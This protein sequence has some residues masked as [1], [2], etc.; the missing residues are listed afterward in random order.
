MTDLLPNYFGGRW[1]DG[2][3]DGATLRDPVTGTALVRVSSEGL[4]LANAFAYARD[5]GGRA[6]RALTLWPACGDAGRDRQDAAGEPGR[7]LRHRDRQLRHDARRLRGG[8]R[9]RASTRSASTRAGARRSATRALCRR[10]A[11]PAGQGR[12]SSS[13][14]HVLVPARGVALFINAFN[15]PAWGLW[16]KAAAALLSG[17]PVIVKPATATA[18][19]TQRMVA[20]VVDGRRPAGRRSVDH[21]RRFNGLLDQLQPSTWSPSPA[22]ARPRRRSAAHPAIARGSVRVNIEAD[23][24]NS[25]AADAGSRSGLARLRPSRARGGARDDDQVGPEMHGHP[26]RAGARNDCSRRRAEAIAA[27]LAGSH[28]RQPAQREGPHG[29]ARQPRPARR[30]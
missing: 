28:G 21:L 18:W 3:G 27:K 2:R 7:V 4:D 20:D 10:R 24:L 17:V 25:R 23:S 1:V 6:L 29:L 26:A 22:R 13:R 30:R 5:T 14:Q 12:R 19:L 11:K 9:R 15:F 16:E 8:H